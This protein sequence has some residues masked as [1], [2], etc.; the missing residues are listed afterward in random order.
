MDE[1]IKQTTDSYDQ[2]SN[3]TSGHDY[4]NVNQV[5]VTVNDVNGGKYIASTTYYRVEVILCT[6]KLP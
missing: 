5:D 1:R 2:G 4:G 6:I 3:A